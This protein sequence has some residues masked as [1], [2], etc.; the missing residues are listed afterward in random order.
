LLPMDA[1]D[2]D[3]VSGVSRFWLF[4]YVVIHVTPGLI[5]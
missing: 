4:L 3:G 1:D 2:L 5:S